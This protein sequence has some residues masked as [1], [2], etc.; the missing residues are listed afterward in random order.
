MSRDSTSRTGGGAATQAGIIYQ[1]EVAAWLCVRILAEQEVASLWGLPDDVTL[2][3][4]RC[5]TE[6]PVDDIL[7]GTSQGG[8]AFIQVKHAVKSSTTQDSALASSLEQFTRQF[9]AYRN[10]T[11]G[12]HRWERPLDSNLDRLVLITSSRSSAPIME[13]LPNTLTRLRTL[14]PDQGIDDAV[15]NEE[16]QKVLSV[17]RAHLSRTWL[18]A[19]GTSLSNTDERDLLKL[20]WVQVLDVAM[21]ERD[22]RESE[23]VLRASII[24]NPAQAGDAWNKLVSAC[25]YYA[26]NRSGADRALLQQRLTTSVE[27]K[28]PR[29]Y[30]SDIEKLRQHSATTL[31]ALSD[32]STIRVGNHVVKINR[33]SSEALRNAAEGQSIVVVGEPGAGKSGALHDLVGAFINENRDTV[34]LAVDKL[35]ARSLGGL[36]IELGLEREFVEIL[37]NWP[38]SEPALLVVDALDAARS[39]ASAQTFYDLLASVLKAPGRWRV[40]ASIRKFDL[41]HNVK[42]HNLFAGKPPT[43]FQSREFYNLSHLNVRLLDVEEWK[44][45]ALQSRELADLIV[46]AADSLRELLL[47]PFNVRLAGELLGGGVSV[48]SLTPIETQIG[49]LDRYWQERVIRHD[50]EGDTREALLTRAVEAMVRTRSLRVNRREVAYEPALGRTLDDVLSSHILSEW[51]PTPDAPADR[52]VLTFAHHMLFDYGTARLLLR[53]TMQSF[54]ARLEQAPEVVIAIRPS[55]VMHFEHEWLRDKERFWDSVFRVIR[56]EQIPEIGKLIGPTVAVDLAKD[57][58]GFAPLV[59]S[60]SNA[61]MRIRETSEKALRHIAGAILV[62]AAD[63]K[64]NL[65]GPT[66]PPWAEFLDQCTS[67]VR[68]STVYT[69]RPVLLTMCDHP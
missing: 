18:D 46:E 12:K 56:S 67:E 36:R 2:E 11:I 15:E 66:A 4:I 24:N 22:Q 41:R 10:G 50:H 26:K 27:I 68:T 61:D 53:G 62:A 49:L 19:T 23:N 48:E 45:I 43:E 29:S 33:P 6:Q 5:E 32:L 47:V 35:E 14:T 13:H 64:E 20:I 40:V 54:V 44:Q 16:Q 34:F 38:G 57:M 52:S 25:A 58:G 39:E 65:V 31:Q 30:R 7:V 28:V 59:R 9:L 60:L 51:G 1:N 42:L 8:H 3:F 17:V 55:I 37:N 63:P 69:L 21:G